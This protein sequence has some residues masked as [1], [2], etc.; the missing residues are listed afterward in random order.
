MIIRLILTAFFV[1]VAIFIR[2]GS[3]AHESGDIVQSDFEQIIAN[4]P[5]KSTG[6]MD[7]GHPPGAGSL[8]T[9]T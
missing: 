3:F 8:P 4:L 7:V 5:G 1:T 9:C 6:A 2:A